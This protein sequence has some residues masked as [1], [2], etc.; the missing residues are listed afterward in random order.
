[1]FCEGQN[2]IWEAYNIPK[3]YQVLG[4][5]IEKIGIVPALRGIYSLI[6]KTGISQMITEVE[7]YNFNEF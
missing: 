1:M 5:N 4:Y 2:S 6:G 3:L 7:V